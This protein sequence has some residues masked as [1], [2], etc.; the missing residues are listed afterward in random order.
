MK[1]SINSVV[2]EVGSMLSYE[3]VAKLAGKPDYA[4]CIYETPRKGDN[5][6]SGI[7][8]RG[9]SVTVEDGMRFD[10]GVTGNA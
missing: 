2:H 10:I 5:Q 4:S 1:V 6:R 8:F 7:L 9:K 3:E